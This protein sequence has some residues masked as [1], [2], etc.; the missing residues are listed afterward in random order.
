MKAV[1]KVVVSLSVLMLGISCSSP[2]EKKGDAAYKASQKLDGNQKRIQLKTA[3]MMYDK[4]IKENPEKVTPKLK[5]RY[6]EM[7]LTRANMIR[8]EGAS[9]MEAISLL[10]EDIEKYIGQADIQPDLKQQYAIFLTQLADSAIAK[11]RYNDAL[12]LIDSAIVR[13]NDANPITQKRKE[14]TSKLAQENFE[15]AEMDYN[16]AKLNEEEEDMVRA[17]FGA[18]TALYFDSTHQEA[19]K[20]LSTIRKAN[21]TTYSA[22]LRVIDPIPDSAIFKVINK[23]DILLAIPTTQ[24][25]GK[26]FTAI[27]NIYNYSYNPLRLRTTDFSLVD[28]NGNSYKALPGKVFPE[29]LDQEHE[30]KLTLK[31][32][33]PKAE[34]VKMVYKSGEDHYTEKFFK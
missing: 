22:Y 18:L 14:L 6:I 15:T 10:R 25:K 16:N 20:L 34:I 11:S 23:Y 3:Y 2:V 4:A 28:V 19:L 8:E 12:E 31:F 27:V 33:A 29:M 1:W 24:R 13:A 30:A 5:N 26:I 21:V 9:H 7:A 17:E 32:P